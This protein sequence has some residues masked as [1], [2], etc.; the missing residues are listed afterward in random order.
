MNRAA[1]RSVARLGLL[2][3]SCWI[4]TPARA[5][6]SAEAQ[7][8]FERGVQLSQEEQWL[9]ARDAF[10]RSAALT[11][12]ASTYYNLAVASLELGLARDALDAFAQF[13]LYADTRNQADYVQQA[14]D[15]RARAR[16][17]VGTMVLLLV[18]GDARVEVDG[19]VEAG[20]GER[21]VLLDPGMH[22][23]KASAPG[24]EATSFE[25]QI[26]AQSMLHRRVELQV[27]DEA[28]PAR[29]IGLHLRSDPSPSA[30]PRDA[31]ATADPAHD[32]AS[33]HGRSLWAQ[34][35]T[36]V[37]IGA[38]VVGAVVTGLVIAAQHGSTPDPYAGRT[39]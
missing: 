26:D 16:A 15:L 10:V 18:P 37:V 31:S 5:D 13:D 33:D 11:P 23:V 2:L 19:H 34:P 20:S 14:A 4:A 32:R 24:R 9:E 21:V 39:L 27:A 35:L 38:V 3:V 22:T 7:A 6:A 25:V 28:A 30:A 36:W 1:L 29:A 12:R 8:L 17:R